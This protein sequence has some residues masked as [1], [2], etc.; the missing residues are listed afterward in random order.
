MAEPQPPTIREGADIDDEPAPVAAASAED[1]KAAAAMSSLDT[2]GEEDGSKKSEADQKALGEAMSRLEI[3]GGGSKSAGPATAEEKKRNGG[4]GEKKKTKVD[5]ADIG[6]LVCELDNLLLEGPVVNLACMKRLLTRGKVEELELNK[7]KAI[8]LL[9]MHE[10]D[11][12]KAIRAF[13]NARI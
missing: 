1:R 3:L 12:V 4:E 13:I 9:K 8:E 6:F 5:Q 2:H 11:A 7:A 10:G